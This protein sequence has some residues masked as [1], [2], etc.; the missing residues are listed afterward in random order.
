MDEDSQDIEGITREEVTDALADPENG[1]AVALLTLYYD[2]LNGEE[3]TTAARVKNAKVCA[4]MLLGLKRY[5]DV[6]GWLDAIATK[7]SD[8]EG[9]DSEAY[10]TF[11]EDEAL[12]EIRMKATDKMF[13][14]EEE[15][16][17]EVEDE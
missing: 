6:V 7:L 11:A 8:D 1:E 13:G 14:D 5:E 4:E 12:E 2:Q 3:P 17:F 16:E 10:M 15:E 9:P